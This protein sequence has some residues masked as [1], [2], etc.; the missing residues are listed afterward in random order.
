MGRPRLTPWFYKEIPKY[1]G[2]YQS[3]GYYSLLY[4]YWDGDLWYRGEK[5][6]DAAVE[7]YN[8]NVLSYGVSRWRG[9]LKF[10]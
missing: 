1:V 6:I 3:P 5:D 8:Y 2:V 7:N 9:I 4:H 10:N